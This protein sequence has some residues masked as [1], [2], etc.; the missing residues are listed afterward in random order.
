MPQRLEGGGREREGAL[1][2]DKSY[3]LPPNQTCYLLLSTS[4]EP[5]TG[6]RFNLHYLIHFPQFWDSR[7][8]SP[9]Y[10][11]GYRDSQSLSNCFFLLLH[12]PQTPHT[13]A[14][15]RVLQKQLGNSPRCQAIQTDFWASEHCH[16]PSLTVE[17]GSVTPQ[18]ARNMPHCIL[19]II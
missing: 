4:S 8:S 2:K 3:V 5:G 1:S 14:C 15:G 10:R 18:A 6:M 11:W 9:F 13:K 19:P 7:S 12:F 17:K 16:T